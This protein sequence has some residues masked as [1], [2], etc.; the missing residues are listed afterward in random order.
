MTEFADFDPNDALD[1]QE[2]ADRYLNWCAENFMRLWNGAKRDYRTASRAAHWLFVIAVAQLHVAED[3]DDHDS[4]LDQLVKYQQLARA[5]ERQSEHFN[6]ERLIATRASL[7]CWETVGQ[8]AGNLLLA[9]RC[10]VS[11]LILIEAHPLIDLWEVEAHDVWGSLDVGCNALT[12]VNLASE[13]TF[14]DFA[15]RRDDDITAKFTW[16]KANNIVRHV[17]MGPLSAN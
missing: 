17:G 16:Q 13:L 15:V 3:A 4:L 6:L 7:D 12:A 11:S 9:A 10:A 2:Q 1:T 8:W 14:E 5:L